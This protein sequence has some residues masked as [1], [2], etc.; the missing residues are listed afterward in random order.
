MQIDFDYP[1]DLQ[2]RTAMLELQN[3]VSYNE[4]I[5][6]PSPDKNVFKADFLYKSLFHFFPASVCSKQLT[7]LK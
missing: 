6:F 3:R 2:L 7:S 4:S 1:A 5:V